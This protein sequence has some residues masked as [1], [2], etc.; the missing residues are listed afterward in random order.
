MKE[1]SLNTE[2]T[3]KIS[4]V[5]YYKALGINERRTVR[6]IILDRFEIEYPSFYARI[7]RGNFSKLEREE[8]ERICGTTF[9][10]E[11]KV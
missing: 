10:W 2:K 7:S 3:A 1:E 9:T 4:F 6:G 5:E 11:E 8:I